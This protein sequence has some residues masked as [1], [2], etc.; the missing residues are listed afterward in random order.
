MRYQ[1]PFV[2]SSST[3]SVPLR[4]L[5][6]ILYFVP[7]PL[8]RC[9]LLPLVFTRQISRLCALPA[10][11]PMCSDGVSCAGTGATITA[12]S[13]SAAAI[14]SFSATVASS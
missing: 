11:P 4:Y 5:L 8:R 6:R 1:L 12:P 3:S 7:G 14:G 10:V 2:F 9:R 13:C